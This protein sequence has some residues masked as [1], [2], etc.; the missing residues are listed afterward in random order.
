MTAD[1]INSFFEGGLALMLTLNIRA[2]LKS[3]RVEGASLWPSLFVTIW[4]FWNLAY[5]PHLHQWASFAGGVGVVI[6]NSTWLALAVYYR[7]ISTALQG[8]LVP[9]V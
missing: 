1:I 3:K 9:T 4:G 8:K 6:G 7:F 2:L 5:Y